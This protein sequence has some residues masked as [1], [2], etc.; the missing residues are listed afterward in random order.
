MGNSLVQW[1]ATIGGFHSKICSGGW[2]K[3]ISKVLEDLESKLPNF[4]IAMEFTSYFRSIIEV[5][6]VCTAKTLD[7]NEAKKIIQDYSN[8]F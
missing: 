6:R 8:N 4:S 5:H 2:D 1:R 7:Q 3:S